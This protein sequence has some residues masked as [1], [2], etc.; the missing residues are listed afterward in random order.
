MRA[1]RVSLMVI[2]MGLVALVA[3]PVL[4]EG[5]FQTFLPGVGLLKAVPSV[6]DVQSYAVRHPQDYR[7]ALAVAEYLSICEPDE[8]RLV[9]LPWEGQRGA[10]PA[11]TRKAYLRCI[12]LKLHSPVARMRYALYQ[13]DKAG[14]LERKEEWSA[15]RRKERRP[16]AS[17]VAHL[18]EAEV[19]LRRA[20]QLEPGNAACDY[21]LVYVHLMLH[22]DA[23]AFAALQSAVTE[24]GWNLHGAE[25]EQGMLRLMDSLHARSRLASVHMAQQTQW[26]WRLAQHTFVRTLI[27]FG[28]QSRKHGDHQRAILCY[29]GIMHLGHVIRVHA[30][31]TLDVWR[32]LSHTAMA[33]ATLISRAEREQIERIKDIERQNQRYREVHTANFAAYLSRHGR[34]DLAQSYRADAAAATIWRA[35][36]HQYVGD[37]LDGLEQT[38]KRGHK[39]NGIVG[40]LQAGL[41]L[42]LL[43]VVGLIS[44]LACAWREQRRPPRWA[45]WQW[46]VTVVICFLPASILALF[47]PPPEWEPLSHFP[48][49]PVETTLG[50]GETLC[51]LGVLLIIGLVWR[52]ASRW[53][54]WQWLGLVVIFSLPV[55]LVATNAIAPDWLGLD[56]GELEPPFVWCFLFG[57]ITAFVALVTACWLALVI[58]LTLVKWSRQPAEDRLGR[59]RAVLATLRM[60]LLPTF[61]LLFVTALPFLATTQIAMAKVARQERKEMLVGEV[62][63]WRIG[64][65][66]VREWR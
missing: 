17:E 53:P 38:I 54:W 42:G 9:V 13:L 7:T 3:V 57:A 65:G 64:T 44:L 32:A 46:L 66:H 52:P 31:W 15:G 45:W 34:S 1:G 61:A 47:A 36:L 35:D 63:Y 60:L 27:G 21:L 18:R 5:V 11:A 49:P 25:A 40:A 14:E 55:V 28:E 56:G 8:T 50:I 16:S 37:V 23:Q 12:S 2:A 22:R 33:T 48:F 10:T 26:P 19:Q 6:G 4:R 51:W 24:P 41:V 62:K 39:A 20:R 58:V 59:G 43:A 30:R 29:Q